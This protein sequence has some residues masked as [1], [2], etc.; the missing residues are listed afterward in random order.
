MDHRDAPVNQLTD[1]QEP[2][3][4]RLVLIGEFS[5]TWHG[6]TV[7]LPPGAQRLLAFLALH[8]QPLQRSYVAGTLWPDSTGVR[9]SACLRS[10]LWRLRRPGPPILG[11][12][13]AHL[14]LADGLA[15]DTREVMATVRRLI[16]PAAPCAASD[17]DPAPLTG[18]LLP[19]W[20]SD[21]WILVE[22]E[23]LRQLCLHGLEA[24]CARLLAFRRYGEAIEA[25]LAAVRTEPLR[26]SAHRVLISVHLA[27]GN[28]AEALRQYRWYERILNEELGLA[29]SPQIGRLVSE[30]RCSA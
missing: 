28:H 15:V 24:M 8:R 30:L 22:R 17:L 7:A 4:S 9:S 18:E 5:L 20:D 21:D 1:H 13:S 29:P 3:T 12:T 27:E 25:G 23:R 14:R 2:A 19:D 11:A 10:A 16:D 6:E 26:E